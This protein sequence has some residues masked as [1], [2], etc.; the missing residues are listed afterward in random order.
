[1]VD[2]LVSNML[3]SAVGFALGCLTGWMMKGGSHSA[4]HR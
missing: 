3:A 1:M 2:V 4:R